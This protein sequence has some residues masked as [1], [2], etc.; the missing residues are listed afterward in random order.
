MTYVRGRD[1]F[2]SK[3]EYKDPEKWTIARKTKLISDLNSRLASRVGLAVIF[4]TLK[5]QYELRSKGRTR[6]QSSFGFCFEMLIHALLDYQGFQNVVQ[7]QDV[8]ISFMIEEGNSNNAEILQRYQRLKR[9]HGE[10]LPFFAGMDFAKKNSSIAIQMADLLA[11]FS[12][13]HA[14]AMEHNDRQ[15]IQNSQYFA[16]LIENITCIG[17]VSTDF[18]YGDDSNV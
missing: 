14:E 1:I 16:A 3:G 7:H 11:F 6:I 12:R 9:D 10:K 17:R 13:R 15:E 8:N 2:S 18:G 4:G 5:H